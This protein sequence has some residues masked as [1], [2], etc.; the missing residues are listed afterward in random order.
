M[1]IDEVHELGAINGSARAQRWG[2]LADRNQ[3][4]LHTH[5]RYGNRIDE[6]E[7]DP[8]YHE[9]MNVA[10]THGLHGARGPMTVRARMWYAPPRCRC[11]PSNPDTSARSR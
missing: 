1:G 10:V 3:P 11:G 6:V 4:V 2:E 7:Y 8:A 9:L 5:D